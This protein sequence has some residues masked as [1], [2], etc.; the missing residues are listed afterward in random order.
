MKSRKAYDDAYN[1]FRQKYKG[2]SRE[3]KDWYLAEPE[4]DMVARPMDILTLENYMKESTD[5][6][7]R[8]LTY[9]YKLSDS[10]DPRTGEPYKDKDGRFTRVENEGTN[11]TTMSAKRFKDL[12]NHIQNNG[13]DPNVASYRGPVGENGGSITKATIYRK[14]NPDDENDRAFIDGYWADESNVNSLGR[15]MLSDL[16][17]KPADVEE[18]DWEPDEDVWRP[19]SGMID[20][21][22]RF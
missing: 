11:H 4:L 8:L 21:V 16:A 7:P 15:K 17:K 1:S 6:D 19:E 9:T 12:L 3:G 22:K 5:E 20:G 13:N 18:D 2:L 14:L 10:V